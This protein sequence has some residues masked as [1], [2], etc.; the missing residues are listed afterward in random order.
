MS[1]SRISNNDLDRSIPRTRVAE[2]ADP[3]DFEA[4]ALPHRRELFA[5]AV[6]MTRDLDDAH[7]LVQETYVRAYAAWPRFS[8]GTNVR[9]WLFRIQSN[10]FINHYRKRKRHRRFA[11]EQP[12]DALCAFYG[13]TRAR[14]FSPEDELTENA[15]SDEVSEALDSL[16]PDYRA[17]VELADIEGERYRDIAAKLRVP[18]GTVMSRLFRARRKLEQA[19]RD[20]AAADYGIVR[21]A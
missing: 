5:A 1:M 18:M 16:G 12:V 17:V 9:A 8:H 2:S 3:C 20:F 6:R 15:L 19:L 10:T 4:Q 7:D 21:T 13:D 14:R 11:E